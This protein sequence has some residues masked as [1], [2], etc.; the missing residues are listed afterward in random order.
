M[1]DWENLEEFVKSLISY[2]QPVRTPLSGGTKHEEDVVG[3]HSVSQCKFTTDKNISILSKDLERL[4]S[5][6]NLLGKFPIFF[7]QCQTCKTVAF[8]ITE[9]TQH[10]VYYAIKLSLVIHMIGEL[11]KL[12]PQT[13]TFPQLKALQA[14][15]KRLG[16]LLRDVQGHISIRLTQLDNAISAKQDDLTSYNLFEQDNTNGS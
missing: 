15:R 11:S 13:K 9:N 2:D 3:I 5:S 4:I 12:L 10:I 8:P 14:E 7:N 1:T 16:N 6:A